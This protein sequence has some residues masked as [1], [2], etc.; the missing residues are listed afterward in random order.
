MYMIYEMLCDV[1]DVMQCD[2]LVPLT[3]SCWIPQS[4]GLVV[5]LST[6]VTLTYKKKQNNI[7]T[8]INMCTNIVLVNKLSPAGNLATYSHNNETFTWVW[9]HIYLEL[10]SWL[11][12]SLNN[13]NN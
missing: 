8:V 3:H 12:S 11:Y 7:K 13:L 1:Y 10:V 2:V 9:H 4:T 5:C 6:G